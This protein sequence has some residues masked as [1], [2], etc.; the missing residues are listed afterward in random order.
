[1]RSGRIGQ[2]SLR[3]ALR[4][5]STNFLR[6]AAISATSLSR[7]TPFGAILRAT[8]TRTFSASLRSATAPIATG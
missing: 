5:P 8:R 3:I 1:M 6:L 7:L 4:L 2:A